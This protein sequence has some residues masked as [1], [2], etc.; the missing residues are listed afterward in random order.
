MKKT[1]LHISK[2]Y[3]PDEGGI[4][5]V[6]KYMAEGLS[7]Y[8]NIVVCYDHHGPTRVEAINGITVYRIASSIKVASQDII[9]SYY[10]HLKKLIRQYLPD[11]IMIHCPNPFLYPIV[12]HLKPQNSK[13]VLLWHSDILGKGI[14]YKSVKSFEQQILKKSDLILTTSLNYVHPSSPVYDYRNKVKVV[15]NGI[16]TRDFIVSADEESKIAE[17]RQRFGN[18]KIVLFV[19]RHVKYKGIDYLIRAEKY[20]QSDCVIVIG[21][22]GPETESLKKMVTSDR[23]KFIGRIPDEEL[24][25]YYH[26]ADIFGFTSITKQ[27]A[28][29]VAL[30]EAMYCKCVP[31]TFAIE[32]SGVN[33]VSIHKE[34]GLVVPRN[35]VKA[36]ASA[37]D[38]LIADDK[39]RARYAEAAHKHIVENFTKEKAVAV[40]NSIY[41]EL[42][43]N[44]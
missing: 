39:L 25:Y 17:I 8:R 18:R 15:P 27:E 7:D 31:V 2:Y 35:D 37:I 6:A 9:F 23:I 5:S 42:L 44:N 13:L 43:P 26:A 28:F 34:T 32:G 11:I 41:S 4:E 33:W 29:G 36:L 20:I 19:G 24:K 40:M 10:S 22:C 1:I 30:A 21:G 3:Y 12:C 38:N 16:D 14:L